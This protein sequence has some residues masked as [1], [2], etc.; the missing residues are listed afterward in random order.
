MHFYMHCSEKLHCHSQVSSIYW[1]F[2]QTV[3]HYVVFLFP[4][5]SQVGAFFIFIF[6]LYRFN[7]KS[8]LQNWKSINI[9]I[10]VFSQYISSISESAFIQHANWVKNSSIPNL[11][12]LNIIF[13]VQEYGKRNFSG[14]EQ[15]NY[16]PVLPAKRQ[17]TSIIKWARNEILFWIYR[18]TSCII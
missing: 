7:W 3:F 9:N 11:I 5:C 15:G 13:H 8:A 14:D 6:L 17:N 1:C 2:I 4:V 12:Y 10:S 18:T 16:F